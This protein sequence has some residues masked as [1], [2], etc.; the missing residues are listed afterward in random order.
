[1]NSFPMV[2]GS[3]DGADSATISTG[4]ANIDEMLGTGGLPA[5]RIVELYGPPGCGKTTLALNFLAAAQEQGATVV[6]VDAERSLSADWA[7]ECGVNLSELI[8]VSPD[9]GAEALAVLES[10]LRTYSVDVVVIDSAAAMVSDEELQASLEDMP[11]ELQ[12]EFL[13]R[14][15]RRLHAMAERTR[16]CVLFVNQTRQRADGDPEQAAA[17]GRALAIH[18]AI[19]I[20]VESARRIGGGLHLR[21]STVKNKLAE[22]FQEAALELRG[23]KATA[24][25]KK[26]PARQWGARKAT[27]GGSAV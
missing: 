19:R 22:P 27:T 25:E 6:Y 20:R 21:L 16:C 11:P 10:L 2:P 14:V 9:S 4:F 13:T 7:A 23:P 17:G 24:M 12:G 1:M 26:P 18:A 8:L 15:L 3:P 5:G